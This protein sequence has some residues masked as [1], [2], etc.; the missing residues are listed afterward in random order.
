MASI[1]SWTE[2]IKKDSDW[3]GILIVRLSGKYL[4]VQWTIERTREWI[5][6]RDQAKTSFFLD[7]SL[8]SSMQE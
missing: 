1:L 7:K 5:T 8:H 3:I 2:A 6:T 4:I